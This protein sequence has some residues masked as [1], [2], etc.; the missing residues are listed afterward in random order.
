M[1]GEEST[2]AREGKAGSEEP[3]ESG[4]V[5]KL[6]PK[7]AERLGFKFSSRAS[8]NARNSSVDSEFGKL[9]S[10]TME[11]KRALTRKEIQ[12]VIDRFGP[13]GLTFG[14]AFVEAYFVGDLR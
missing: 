13:C 8:T 4:E 1:A 11:L 14:D 7:E 5:A 2:P 9:K 3:V 10:S 12:D 6:S